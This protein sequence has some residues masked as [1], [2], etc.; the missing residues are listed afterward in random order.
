MADDSVPPEESST[1]AA[2]RRWLLVGLFFVAVAVYGSLVP[3]RWAPLELS[4]AIGR[5][6]EILDRP[7]KTRFRSDFAANILLF[8]PIGYCF[9][10]GLAG[11]RRKRVSV[12]LCVPLVRLGFFQ[13]RKRG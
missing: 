5:F 3:F 4:E 8:V 10:A 2:R 1:A 12:L 9:L 6:R 7:V 11:D 13:V